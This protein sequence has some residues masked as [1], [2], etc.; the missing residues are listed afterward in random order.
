MF[1]K[2]YKNLNGEDMRRHKCRCEDN[3]KMDIS[4]IECDD[5]YPMIWLK[6]GCSEFKVIKMDFSE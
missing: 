5:V 4:A 3:I 6:A 1:I 2:L